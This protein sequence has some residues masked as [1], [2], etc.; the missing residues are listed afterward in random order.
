VRNDA[1][2]IAKLEE[3]SACVTERL[4]KRDDKQQINSD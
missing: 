4:I 2:A 1:N 3:L